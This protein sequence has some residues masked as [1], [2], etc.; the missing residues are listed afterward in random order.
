MVLLFISDHDANGYWRLRNDWA[1]L[2]YLRLQNTSALV[3]MGATVLN[4]AE[5]GENSLIEWV[6]SNGRNYYS[7]NLAFDR[8]HVSFVNWLLKKSKDTEPMLNIIMN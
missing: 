6:V 4:H 8:Q 7:Q 5:I 3:G 1:C 2:H